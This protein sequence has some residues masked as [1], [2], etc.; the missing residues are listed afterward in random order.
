MRKGIRR[1]VRTRRPW[2]CV[3][4]RTWN[5]LAARRQLN[6]PA[7]RVLAKQGRSA[8]AR[9]PAASADR[10]PGPPPAPAVRANHRP[11]PDGTSSHEPSRARLQRAWMLQRL[12]SR[13]IERHHVSAPRHGW[14]I[15]AAVEFCESS[16]SDRAL[17][18]WHGRQ[19]RRRMPL[20]PIGG[21][22]FARHQCRRR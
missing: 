10:C 6:R 3:W 5:A 14:P 11:S 7:T 12:R 2:P 4:L 16:V 1:A 17:C 18:V 15:G 20:A 21:A 22:L 9:H 19:S 13:S 8:L